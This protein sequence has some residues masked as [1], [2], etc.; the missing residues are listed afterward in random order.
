MNDWLLIIGMGVLTYAIRL[1]FIISADRLTIPPVIRRA[2]RYVPPAVLT[3]IVVPEMLMPT[4]SLDLVSP[5]FF[6]GLIA[7][8]AAY[9]TRNVMWT[10][11]VGMV[12]LWLL[13]FLLA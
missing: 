2:L 9:L 8:A 11:A 1:S 13:Q 6:A 12:S 5:R 4:G 7:I 10:V 3:A